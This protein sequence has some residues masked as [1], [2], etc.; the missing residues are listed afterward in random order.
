MA[1]TYTPPGERGFRLP[2]F[3]LKGVDGKTYCS[4]D[5]AKYRATVFMF[6]CNH[7]PYVQAIE[8][9]LV[10]MARRLSGPD[11]AFVAICSNDPDDYPEDSFPAMTARAQQKGYPFVYLHDLS[12]DVAK[13]FGAV[14]TPDFF[15]FDEKQSLFYRGRLDDSWK[16]PAQVRRRELEEALRACLAGDQPPLRPVPSMG[17]SIKWRES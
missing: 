1:L 17:C 6:I 9:R 5:F 13:S 12:Q 3:Q 4:Q 16:D 10:E 14:C 2:E 7:C 8:D 11:V 15:I